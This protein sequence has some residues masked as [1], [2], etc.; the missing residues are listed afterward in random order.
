M[1]YLGISRIFQSFRIAKQ[2]FHVIRRLQLG[3]KS[4]LPLLWKSSKVPCMRHSLFHQ[5]TRSPGR[6]GR[7]TRKYRAVGGERPTNLFFLV[8]GKEKFPFPF[9]SR[10]FPRA[11]AATG[12]K[13]NRVEP[14]V[15]R[16]GR[17]N[18]PENPVWK[19]SNSIWPFDF[20]R[21]VT[22][23]HTHSLLLLLLKKKKFLISRR[24]IKRDRDRTRKLLRDSKGWIERSGEDRV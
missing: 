9:S 10:K 4:A 8:R 17:A 11:L 15:V 12:K 7:K 1:E 5:V 13:M 3:G 18:F 2:K 21:F 6:V 23:V 22:S 24:I 19:L 14:I 20:S 16:L